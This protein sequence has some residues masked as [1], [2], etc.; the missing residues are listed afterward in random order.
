[1]PFQVDVVITTKATGA[2]GKLDC[3]G[4][5]SV[6]PIFTASGPGTPRPQRQQRDGPGA[7]DAG[8][9]RPDRGYTLDL[10]LNQSATGNTFVFTD[11]MV[12]VLA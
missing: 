3:F 1:M 4:A 5:A 9:A 10:G 12:E 7:G 8:D 11:I 6:G 2:L